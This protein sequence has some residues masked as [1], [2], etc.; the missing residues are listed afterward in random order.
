MAY[1]IN[2]S[3]G[4]FQQGGYLYKPNRG[5]MDTLVATHGYLTG[6][7]KADQSTIESGIVVITY[8]LAKLSIGNKKRS[9]P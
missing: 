2:K 3:D 7:R 1:I 9:L 4:D 6:L 5:I 8:L